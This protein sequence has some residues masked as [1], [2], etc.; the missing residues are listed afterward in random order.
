MGFCVL[1]LEKDDRLNLWGTKCVVR[2][3]QEG[4]EEEETLAEYGGGGAQYGG[5]SSV[6]L[7]DLSSLV[8]SS[9]SDS[10]S[11]SS[12]RRP[13]EYGTGLT[14][15]SIPS[16]SST[17]PLLT[18]LKAGSTGFAD[19]GGTETLADNRGAAALPN[20]AAKFRRF[21][22]WTGDALALELLWVWG[23]GLALLDDLGRTLSFRAH[24]V[25][26]GGVDGV[27]RCCFCPSPASRGEV[28]AQGT[29]RI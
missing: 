11:T 15:R 23:L 18:D 17:K 16:R 21:R 12:C 3:R 25:G 27:D 10:S 29:R 26:E 8:S 2:K 7:S 4:M 1:F 20:A 24:F 13:C 22:A 6:R 28:E 5:C 19:D 14:G 9:S